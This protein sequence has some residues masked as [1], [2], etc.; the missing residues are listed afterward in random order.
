MGFRIENNNPQEWIKRPTGY[1]NKNKKQK[2][3]QMTNHVKI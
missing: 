1:Q 2:I 3:A